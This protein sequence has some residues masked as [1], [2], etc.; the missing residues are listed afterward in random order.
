MAFVPFSQSAH[1][2]V[3]HQ[4]KKME[5]G[6]KDPKSE[7]EKNSQKFQKVS[8]RL[9]ADTRINND[10]RSHVVTDRD[11]KSVLTNESLKRKL[12]EIFSTHKEN[13]ETVKSSMKTVIEKS[14]S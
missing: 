6:K 2:S 14:L 8:D 12:Q 1:E 7:M 10:D 9:A 13:P 4:N 5:L 3:D 11:L